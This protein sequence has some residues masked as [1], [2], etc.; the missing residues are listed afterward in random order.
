MDFEFLYDHFLF[1]FISSIILFLLLY[2]VLILRKKKKRYDVRKITI[3]DID[4]MDGYEFEHYL[5]VLLASVGFENT[6]LTKSSR[7][8]GADLLFTDLNGEKVVVQ[9]KR[10]SN[11]LGLDAVQEIYA[12]KAY[13]DADNALIITN[14]EQVS[15]PCKKLACATGVKII[16]RDQLKQFVNEAKKGKIELMQ[17]M[18]D[19]AFEDVKYNQDDSIE[20]VKQKRNMIQAGDYFLKLK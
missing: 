19:E 7:D 3:E 10:L 13:Y 20:I 9:A 1:I 2:I 6:Q 5:Y 16:K 12:A 14:T 18:I 8:F 11:Q 15:A 17:T 4:V